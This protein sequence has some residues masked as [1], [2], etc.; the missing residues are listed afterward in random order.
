[1]AEVGELRLV[2]NYAVADQLVAADGERH[3]S[4][5]PR[6]AANR[7]GWGGAVAEL[8]AAVVSACDVKFTIDR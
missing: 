4:G 1:V 7:H 8:L 5:D 6:D 2:G 3:Q